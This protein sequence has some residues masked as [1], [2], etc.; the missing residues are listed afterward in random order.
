MFTGVC[1]IKN[2]FYFTD[3]GVLL[4]LNRKFFL[5]PYIIKMSTI[6]NVLFLFS[7]CQ[8]LNSFDLLITLNI[9]ADYNY[10]P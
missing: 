7:F 6:F 8:T 9:M 1:L 4:I 2:S 10:M 3:F 5:F